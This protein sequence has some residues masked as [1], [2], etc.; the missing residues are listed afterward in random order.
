M[1][2]LI[3]ILLPDRP[4]SLGHLAE[5]IGS[6]G[7]D[8]QSVDVVEAFPDGTVMDD[9]VV[10]LPNGV[11]ADA[12][13]TAAHDVEGV[14]VDS[15]RPF[16]GT[17]DRR[18]QIRM[19]AD[20]ASARNQANSLAH[21]IDNIPRVLTSTWAILLA[22]GDGKLHRV[23]ASPAAPEDDGTTPDVPEIDTARVLRPD[24]EK[25]IPESW[26]LLD[27]ALTAA[28]LHNRNELLILGRVGG[29]DYQPSE[30]EHFGNLAT[31]LGK[32]MDS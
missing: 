21:L 32:L 31:I 22:T 18:G 11:M 27:T 4:G 19:L 2:Y 9:M 20:V 17:V 6:T 14:E 10:S 13:I 29:P 7:G 24:T 30:V 23:T 1:S 15:I 26:A 25:W 5:A 3:R 8:I 12:L 28:P 16:S